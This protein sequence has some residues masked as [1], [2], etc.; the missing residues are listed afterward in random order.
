MEQRYTGEVEDHR[1]I[2]F[3]RSV[4]KPKKTPKTPKRPL[5][6]L[7]PE[8]LLSEVEDLGGELCAVMEP[9]QVISSLTTRLVNRYGAAVSSIW[10]V[11]ADSTGLDLV[12]ED[13]HLDLPRDVAHTPSGDTLLG[14]AVSHRL[15]QTITNL[16]SADD[17][18][19]RWAKQHRLKF[20]GAYPLLEDSRVQGVLMVAYTKTPPK[21]LLALFRLHARLASMALRDAELLYSTRRTL[22]KLSFLVEASKALNST[23][24]LS[25]L[26]GRI[27]DVA[28]THTEAERGTL[29]LVDESTNE[30]W[31]LI[32]H[33]LEKQEIRLPLGKGIAGHVAKS[34]EVVLIPDAYSDPRFNP[35]VDKRTGYHTR[36]I[37][38]VPIRNK[39]GK[40]I[41]ALQLL[42]K[43]HG[44]FTDEDAD[45]L[46]TLSGHMALALENAQLHQQLLDKERMEKELAL[47]RGIQRSLLPDTAPMVEGFDIALLNEPCYAVGGDY[48]DFLTLGPQTLL[49]VIADVEG[50]GVSSALVMSNLQATLRALVLHLH[51]LD[52]IAESLNRMILNDTRSQKYLSIFIGLVDV[53]RK[54]L[55]YINCGHVPPVIVRPDHEP[56]PLTEGGMVIGLFE[57][58]RYQRG[59][60]KLQSGDILVL[61]TDGI[62]ESMNTL[63]DEY[64]I[65]RVVRC[66]QGVADKSAA[67]IVSAV[68]ADVARFSRHGT[69]LDDKVMITLKVL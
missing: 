32:A 21:P 67:E 62:T 51:S 42:N 24:D 17:S 28:K 23:L 14:R 19:L 18:L 15:P 11:R 5:S 56:I 22:N 16:T 52:E 34:G 63:Q 47:A 30:I 68:N 26:L 1:G 54:G 36:T 33:G 45:F 50:K 4:A 53:R 61:C 13:G 38:C 55:H 20:L 39:A 7:S 60:V 64:G 37:L 66:I 57:N 58:A 2:R 40:I 3:A 27:L 69:H 9:K 59:H 29:F 49:T 44:A 43:Q 46:L 8:S 65:E 10:S 41:A 6:A 25:E 31:S 48:Y 12:S 35:E